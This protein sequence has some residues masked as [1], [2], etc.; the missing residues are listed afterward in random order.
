[1]KKILIAV[2]LLAMFCGAC[3][4]EHNYTRYDCI[5]TQACEAGAIFEDRCGWTWFVEG[6]GY[7]VGQI[8]DLKM[9]DNLTSAYIDD[10]IIKK[11]IKK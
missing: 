11:V 3:Y 5:V 4:C 1:M 10:D 8:A 9:H 2:L 7:E 6:E